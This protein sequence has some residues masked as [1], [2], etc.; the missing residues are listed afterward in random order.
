[1]NKSQRIHLNVDDNF[2]KHI[3]V[4]LEQNVDTLEFLTMSI[5]TR[6][7][8]QNFNADYGVLVG[9][10]NA[11]NGIGVENA[12]V[13]I[14]IPI[15]DEDLE[16]SLIRSIYPY[17][18]PRDVNN[19]GKRY[20]LL[21]RVSRLSSDGTIKPTQP[22]GSFPTKEEILTNETYLTV[23]EKYYKYTTTTNSAG[24]YMIF[25][26]PTGTQTA[27]MSVDITDIGVY[28]MTPAAMVTNLGYSPNLFTDNN[29]RIKPS[30]DLDDLPNIETQEISV[31]VIPFWGDNENFEIGITRQDFR[32]RA[33][34][35]ANSVIFGTIGTMGENSTIGD[36]SRYSRRDEGFY[37]MSRNMEENV[38]I[39]TLRASDNL[40]IRVFTYPPNVNED[41]IIYDLD[42]TFTD[43]D[44]YDNR[45]RINTETDI[46]E[47]D[48]NEY[49]SYVEN[50]SFVVV[51]PCNRDRK[52][53]NEFNEEIPVSDDSNEGVFT[54][55][56]GMMLV[57]YV[58]DNDLPIDDNFNGDTFFGKNKALVTRGISK[59]PQSDYSLLPEVDVDD[60][61]I[62]KFEARMSSEKWRKSYFTLE[63]NTFNTIAQFFPTRYNLRYDKT[64]DYWRSPY[65]NTLYDDDRIKDYLISGLMFKTSGIDYLEEYEFLYDIR[66][67]INETLSTVESTGDTTMYKTYT[68]EFPNNKSLVREYKDEEGNKVDVD[69]TYFGGQ[70]INMFMVLPQYTYTN[71]YSYQNRY[72]LVSTMLF[73]NN[74]YDY[75]N[76]YYLEHRSGFND[77]LVF[78]PLRG[79]TNIIRGTTFKT[80]VVRV[81]RTHLTYFLTNENVSNIKGIS[82]G[83]GTHDDN[84]DVNEGDYKY[85]FPNNSNIDYFYTTAY[86]ENVHGPYIF[87]GFYR[88]DC[89]RLLSELNLI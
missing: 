47:L 78:G 5:D 57:D 31:D 17:E 72:Q 61:D 34:I 37:Y 24:D 8:Y 11:N 69:E 7:V 39:R 66:N 25:G 68:Y 56:L 12:R 27:H 21:P 86:D 71:D 33:E 88:N 46:V 18:T 55:F 70:W 16:N 2:D 36:P 26:V 28:S 40:R 14:F 20:N 49:Y 73:G 53:R 85:H 10:V 1:M 23:Y 51:V 42:Q 60:P 67:Q 82:L 50:G 15:D 75:K 59:I 58:D 6:D 87:R 38:D 80:D 45:H 19:Q 74:D 30:D 35:K 52:K 84:I 77:Q 44:D 29:T 41:D 13:S 48:P 22:F 79:T 4:R 43:D 9:R 81:P 76:S 65:T 62:D 32:I 54:K 64:S 3:K 63:H 83:D 89:V